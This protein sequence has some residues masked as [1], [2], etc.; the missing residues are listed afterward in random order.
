MERLILRHQN[1]AI[2]LA[3]QPPIRLLSIDGSGIENTN[4]NTASSANQDGVSYMDTTLGAGAI[5]LQLAIIANS[6]EEIF[7]HRSNLLT[8]LNPKNGLITLEYYIPS[9]GDEVRIA[10]VVPDMVTFPSGRGNRVPGSFQRV[11]VTLLHTSNVWTAAEQQ[12]QDFTGLMGGLEFPMELGELHFSEIVDVDIT[13]VY[14]GGN[15]ATPV[16]LVLQGTATKPITITNQ[17]TDESIIINRDMTNDKIIIDTTRG[18]VQVMLDGIGSIFGDVDPTS[19]FFYL[20]PGLNNIGYTSGAE[21]EPVSLTLSWYN[22]YIG[23]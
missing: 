17:T 1:Q 5:T 11:V 18:Q 10:K 14:H 7:T 15:M 13:P 3:N 20:A 9:E 23:V 12:S 2:E 8:I 22:T 4:I 21:A 6:R 16:K 19:A